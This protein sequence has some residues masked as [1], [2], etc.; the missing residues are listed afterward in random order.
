MGS[1]GVAIPHVHIKVVNANGEKLAFGEVGELMVKGPNVMKGYYKNL[2]ETEKTL[3]NSWLYTGDLA[4]IDQENYVYIVDRSK[5]MIIKNGFNIYPREIEEVILTC[6]NIAQ[7]A[8]IG[9]SAE[10]HGEE[11]KAF[12]VLKPEKLLLAQEDRYLK[13]EILD[14][15]KERIANYK[16]PKE[17]EFRTELPMNAT[18]KILKSQL[19]LEHK[20]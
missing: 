7:A 14:F 17:I 19:R 18:G 1:I 10:S 15:L 20:D 16:I 5:D 2:E 8:V 12:I 13:K 4:K 6:P 11:V 9:I 3:K